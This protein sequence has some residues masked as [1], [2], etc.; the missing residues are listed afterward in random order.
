MSWDDFPSTAHKA[1]PLSQPSAIPGEPEDGPKSRPPH[2]SWG[3]GSNYILTP[4]VF[5][6]CL[7]CLSLL[8]EQVSLPLLSLDLG[9]GERSL[10][11]GCL[12]PGRDAR[13]V[14]HPGQGCWGLLP[15]PAAH[16]HRQC[17]RQHRPHAERCG[18]QG[19]CPALPA[20]STAAAELLCG[21]D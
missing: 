11:Q 13:G 20:A 9:G 6:D 8:P 17:A 10:T 5:G 3:S 1:G 4:P 16:G 7:T 12:S 21:H 18:P 19:H 15:P 14:S 2:S